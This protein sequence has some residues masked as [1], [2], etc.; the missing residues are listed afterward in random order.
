MLTKIAE[1]TIKGV[2]TMDTGA[3]R[4]TERVSYTKETHRRMDIMRTL[5]KDKISCRK[6]AGI[7]GIEVSVYTLGSH[8][9]DGINVAHL[10]L[11]SGNGILWDDSQF[12]HIKIERF[13]LPEG[14]APYTKCVISG[15]AST[16]EQQRL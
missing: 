6:M 8:K 12:Y 11:N 16:D 10:I 1:F 2:Y 9:V 4:S 13:I 14:Q 3:N 15:E 7:L 5:L